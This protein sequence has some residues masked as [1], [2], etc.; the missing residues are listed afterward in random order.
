MTSCVISETNTACHHF[1]QL[2]FVSA[3][4]QS[5][6]YITS[7]N[8]IDNFP[9]LYQLKISQTLR[10]WSRDWRELLSCRMKYMMTITGIVAYLLWR[11]GFQLAVWWQSW[12]VWTMDRYQH[13]S[14]QPCKRKLLQEPF[15][16]TTSADIRSWYV[17]LPVYSI[18]MYNWFGPQ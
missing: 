16:P 17:N 3:N 1:V 4:A 10:R 8:P 15:L 14:C 9:K 2:S 7:P 11:T 13:S 18:Q 5:E 6:Q 12:Y